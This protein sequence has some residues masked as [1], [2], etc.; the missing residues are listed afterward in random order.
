MRS[1]KQKRAVP[2][3]AFYREA[4]N[5]E[6]L[7]EFLKSPTDFMRKALSNGERTHE[8]SETGECL[9]QITSLNSS[10]PMDKEG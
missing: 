5:V 2:E 8:H 3:V 1:P 7:L 9:K 4:K 10:V 6:E